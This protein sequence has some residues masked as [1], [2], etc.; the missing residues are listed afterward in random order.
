MRTFAPPSRS[1]T[2]S[3]SSSTSSSSS[4]SKKTKVKSIIYPDFPYTQDEL[5]DMDVDHFNTLISKLDDIRQ[6]VLRDM[7]KRGKNKHAARNCRK[8][9][10]DVIDNLDNNVD[11]LEKQREL[12]LKEQ[13]LLLEETRQIHE[14]TVWLNNYIL[15]RLYD[16]TGNSYADSDYT[17]EYTTDG[18]VYVVPYARKKQGKTA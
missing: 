3:T 17:L 1:R 16:E 11:L 9:K 7:R 12:L 15:E 13:Q 8:R 2:L 18:N 5:I 10:L 6:L 14:K 4:G